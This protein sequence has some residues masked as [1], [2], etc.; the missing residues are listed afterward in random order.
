[1]YKFLFFIVPT[2]SILESNVFQLTVQEVRLIMENMPINK[3]TYKIQSAQHYISLLPFSLNIT[4]K[5]TSLFEKLHLF[6]T[7][8]FLKTSIQRIGLSESPEK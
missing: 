8:K 3:D 1:M 4:L 5:N 2:Q 6:E 7:L